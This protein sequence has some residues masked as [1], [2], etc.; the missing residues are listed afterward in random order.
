MPQTLKANKKQGKMCLQYASNQASL[1]EHLLEEIFYFNIKPELWFQYKT[2]RGAP[3]KFNNWRVPYLGLN[4]TIFV[5][6]ILSLSGDS[7]P[8]RW[9]FIW[10]MPFLMPEGFSKRMMRVMQ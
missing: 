10:R 6:Y 7:V 3:K 1:T 5:K 8:L 2:S 9:I 4:L